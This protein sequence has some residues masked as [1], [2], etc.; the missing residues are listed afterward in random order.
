[1]RPLPHAPRAQRTSPGGPRRRNAAVSLTSVSTPPDRGGA[2]D[3]TQ[4]REW[5][6]DRPSRTVEAR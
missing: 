2:H 5:T 6:P 1:M 3:G 4:D